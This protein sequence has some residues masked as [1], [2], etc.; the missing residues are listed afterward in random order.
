MKNMNEVIHKE[1][2]AGIDESEK[3]SMVE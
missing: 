3:L 1:G 2:E